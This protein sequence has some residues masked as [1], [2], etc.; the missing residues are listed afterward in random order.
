MRFEELIQQHRVNRI[1]AHGVR[2]VLCVIDHQIAI[3]LFH[4]LSHQA[5]LRAAFGID[6]RFVAEGDRPER[7]QHV[8][9]LVHLV[10]VLLETGRG[11]RHPKLTAAVY[12]NRCAANRCPINAGHK[13]FRL[14]SLC[15]N[16]DGVGLGRN[17][18]VADIDIVIARGEVDSG[19]NAKG[20]VV[21]AGGVGNER[22]STISRVFDAGGVEIE[23]VNTV[24]RVP[25]AGGVA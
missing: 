11:R 10:N 22:K 15:A 7:Q 13:R 5:K 18:S 3:D 24:G 9:R 16:A 12:L 4:F 14:G 6:F 8:A 17:T 23:R 25:K 19:V 21:V 1:V 20:D 2:L